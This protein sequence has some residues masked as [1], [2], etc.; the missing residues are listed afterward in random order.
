MPESA[1]RGHLRYQ[2]RFYNLLAVF[3]LFKDF[4]FANH[5]IPVFI[6]LFDNMNVLRCDV[7]REN[8]LGIHILGS[9][10]V[11]KEVSTFAGKN[12]NVPVA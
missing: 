8:T 12:V 7:T 9:E 5:D 6:Y 3:A 2:E 4:H 11:L 10:C 1:L